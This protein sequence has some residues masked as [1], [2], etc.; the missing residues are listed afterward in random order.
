MAIADRVAALS[1][2]A[3]SQAQAQAANLVNFVKNAVYGAAIAALI[4][5]IGLAQTAAVMSKPLPEYGDGILNHPGGL[6]V[7]GDK[8][9][10]ELV[11]EPGKA[12]YWSKDTDTIYDL[13]PG[14]SVI[15]KRFISQEDMMAAS[16]GFMTPSVLKFLGGE[17]VADNARLEAKLDENASRIERAVKG[18]PVQNFTLADGEWKKSVRSG[19]NT[20]HYL[21]KNFS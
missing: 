8:R 15:P 1:N 17:R 9:E 3:M 10:P 2:I 21:N 13:S 6:A 16:M 14:T 20:I 7:L 11:M 18:I 4:A 12:P 5:A 19:S